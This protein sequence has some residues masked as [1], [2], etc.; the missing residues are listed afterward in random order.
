MTHDQ[1]PATDQAAASSPTTPMP[2]S[3]AARRDAAGKPPAPHPE[4]DDS[5]A[6][7]ED[8]GSAEDLQPTHPAGVPVPDALKPG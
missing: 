4:E 2:A 1:D 8:P 5:V 3:D 6:G 7:E